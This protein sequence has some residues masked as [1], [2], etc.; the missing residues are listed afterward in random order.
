MEQGVDVLSLSLGGLVM[1]LEAPSTY[2]EAILTCV[3][4]GIP[5][6]AAIG[7]EGQQTTGSPGN[8]LFALSIGATD[9]NDRAA[10]FSGGRTQ[11]IRQSDFINP[12]PRHRVGEGSGRIRPRPPLRLRP[13][14]R[15]AGRGLRAPARILIGS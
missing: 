12:G 1:D 3:E 9:P 2:T 6:V 7:N 15:S 10:G 5:V 4:A 13:S 14:G 8:D 11:I